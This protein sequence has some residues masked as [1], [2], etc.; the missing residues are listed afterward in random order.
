MKV[1]SKNV[2]KGLLKLKIENLEDLWY[3]SQIISRGDLISASST[4]KIEKGNEK[5]RKKIFL[6]LKVEKIEF[7][8]YSSTLRVSGKI[9]EC[10]DEDVPIG[11]YHSIIVEPGVVLSIEKNELPD[12]LLRVVREASTPNY[13]ILVC[14]FDRE[15]ALFAMITKQGY[16]ILSR[17]K[18]SVEKKY[19]KGKTENFYKRI[20]TI[21]EE[22]NK[23]KNPDRIII[24]SPS[25]W[26]EY[27][28]KELS[29][30]IK[31]RIIISSCNSVSAS[32]INEI[33]KR[34]ETKQ[35]LRES[36]LRVENTLIEELLKEIS[37]NGLAVYG[38]DEVEEAVNF[39]AIDK[40]LILDSL[41]YNFNSNE[42]II[43]IVRGAEKQRA[44]IFV[45]NSE[46]EPGKMLSG[47]GGLA[48]I[49]RFKFK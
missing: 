28:M 12:Y 11:N 30:D 29:S 32:A 23:S 6:K 17:I 36:R 22:Y 49:L 47:L 14:V 19:V 35:A 38:V 15:E 45:I 3:L 4:R 18:G 10:N 2:K 21:I 34:P 7:Q 43:K 33:M 41:M 25:F 48:A 24:A 37:K 44:K 9:L 13:K 5:V 39:G 31:T 1:L 8:K 42:R 40:L 20:A 27:L 16:K 26:S 46:F